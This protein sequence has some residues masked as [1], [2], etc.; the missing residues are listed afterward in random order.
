MAFSNDGS[1]M[2]V[3]GSAG[4]D[5]NEYTL[6]TAFDTSTLRFVNSTSVS[7]Q[8]SAPTGMAFSNDGSKMF[9]IGG[10]GDD[11]NEYTL[12]TAFDASTL[13]FVDATSVSDQEN[14]PQ[15]IAFSNDGFKMFVIGATEDD[16]NEYALTTPFDA[17]TLRFVDATSVSDQEDNPQGIAFSNDGAKMFVTGTVNNGIY[18]YALSSVYPITVVSDPFLTTWGDGFSQPDDRHTC[19]GIFRRNRYRLG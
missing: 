4:D 16:V 18:E 17:S 2:F 6:S 12:S 5:V 8:E 14:S 9:V 19:R 10:F 1:K 13:S 11:V 15:G 7:D 3:I